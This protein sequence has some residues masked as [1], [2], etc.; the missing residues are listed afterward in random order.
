ME[1]P[2]ESDDVLQFLVQF[3]KD[4]TENDVTTKDIEECYTGAKCLHQFVDG[5]DEVTLLGMFLQLLT[6]RMADTAH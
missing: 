2:N 6:R 5:N 3:A 1:T 4:I